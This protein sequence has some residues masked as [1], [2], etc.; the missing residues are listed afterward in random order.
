LDVERVEIT[1]LQRWS[2]GVR[3]DAIRKIISLPMFSKPSGC[4]SP[5]RKLA[6]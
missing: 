2:A 6:S 5:P 4:S 3:R 1:S